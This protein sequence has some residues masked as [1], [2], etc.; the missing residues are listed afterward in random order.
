MLQW[1]YNL[2]MSFVTWV[3]SLFGG[4][5]GKSSEGNKEG[6]SSEQN[7]YSESSAELSPP[8]NQSPSSP[9]TLLP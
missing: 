1:L 4:S 2:L 9:P 8:P 7:Q 3:L 6:G 5:L